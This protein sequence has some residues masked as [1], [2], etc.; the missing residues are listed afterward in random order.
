MLPQI[1]PLAT[2]TKLPELTNPTRAQRRWREVRS[3]GLETVLV[4]ALL[5]VLHPQRNVAA[6]NDV[7]ERLKGVARVLVRVEE[8]GMTFGHPPQLTAT[9]VVI[10]QCRLPTVLIEIHVALGVVVD[11][12]SVVE[13]KSV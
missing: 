6:G 4:A 3:P 9:V 2:V 11:R 7:V 10:H 5:F 1:K 8:L 12:K 13:G